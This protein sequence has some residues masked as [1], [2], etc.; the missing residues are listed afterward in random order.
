MR[1]RL[2]AI[3]LLL[4]LAL[5]AGCGGGSSSSSSGGSGGSTSDVSGSI[6]V[7]G[8]WSGP[9]QAAFQKVI[10]GFNEQYPNV[11]VKYTSAGDQL[12][13]Q[14]ST[15]VAGGNP[16]SVAFVAQPGLIKDFVSK[17]ALKPIEYAKS[18]VES[19]LGQS[20]AD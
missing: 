18:D 7:M 10:D 3:G 12:P 20:A 9:E 1:T 17:G 5:A 11:S 19:N 14:L 13:T 15:A 16:P 2:G 4:V 8:V 6:S